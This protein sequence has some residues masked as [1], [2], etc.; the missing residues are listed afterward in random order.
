MAKNLATVP[1]YAFAGEKDDVVSPENSK[2]MIAAIQKAGGTKAKLKVY[3][4]AG[5][6]AKGIVYNS[7]SSTTG[8][9]PKHVS[10]NWGG[11]YLFSQPLDTA[12]AEMGNATAKKELAGRAIR[13]V[14]QE[15]VVAD[16]ARGKSIGRTR[17]CVMVEK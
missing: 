8:C 3:P 1:V 17:R 4:D 13:E 15:P 7:Q 14:A 9:F 10:R 6:G 16:G 2:R 5:H 12:A 11:A